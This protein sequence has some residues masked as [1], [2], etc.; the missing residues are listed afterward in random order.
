MTKSQLISDIILRVTK[1]KPADDLE[2]EPKQVAFW[3]K[4][5]LDA[6]V[7]EKINEDLG[8][9]LR[10]PDFYVVR[11]ACKY[12]SKEDLDCVDDDKDRLYVKTSK[13][14]FELL[15]DRGVIRVKTSEGST[16]HKA[17]L[18]SIDFV[19]HME[20]AK[21]SQSNLV[22]YRDG[23]QKLVIAGIPASMQELVDIIVWYVPDTDIE[24]FGDDEEL[25]I[26]GELLE[27][28]LTRV[29]M[30]ARRQMFG[31]ADIENDGEDDLPNVVTNG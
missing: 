7:S 8:N 20:F 26:E 16:V 10:V 29:E 3:I 9:N 24:C 5:V 25:P 17:T 14:V 18:S 21:P 4:L 2:L 15:G 23:Q 28:L 19:E 30:I 11:E 12:I 6:M 27:E 31:V 13:P 22:Y 1:G